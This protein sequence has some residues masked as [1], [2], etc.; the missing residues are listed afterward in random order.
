MM[1]ASRS[2]AAAGEAWL[3]VE[4]LNRQYRE[5]PLDPAKEAALTRLEAY[6]LWQERLRSI[7]KSSAKEHG[8]PDPANW[9]ENSIRWHVGVSLAVLTTLEAAGLPRSEFSDLQSSAALRALQNRLR[10][11]EARADGTT[12]SAEPDQTLN[13]PNIGRDWGGVYLGSILRSVRT[14]GTAIGVRPTLELKRLVTFYSNAERRDVSERLFTREEYLDAA[15][16]LD[17]LG[18]IM[19]AAGR[20]RGASLRT[21]G[22]LLA[23]LA[24]GSPRRGEAGQAKRTLVRPNAMTSHASRRLWIPASDSK[25]RRSR[26][27]MVEDPAAVRLLDKACQ[28]P[29]GDELFRLP[30]GSHIALPALDYIL[31]RVTTLAMGVPASSNLLRKANAAAEMTPSARRAQLGHAEERMNEIY[32]PRL[33]SEG[34]TILANAREQRLAA[35]GGQQRGGQS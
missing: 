31:R 28:G 22:Q 34:V 27:V 20:T 7:L 9:S 21:G 3:A 26:A 17:V 6:P 1:V 18:R 12:S 35:A 19:L 25:T 13:P 15:A 30:D 10:P 11:T 16:A 24:D 33:A 4:R 5:A 8:A 2:V 32:H 29:G 14:V 23:L